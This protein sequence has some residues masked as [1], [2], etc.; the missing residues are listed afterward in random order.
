MHTI[1]KTHSNHLFTLI[2][3]L[4]VIAIIA[5]LASILLPALSSSRDRVREIYCINNIRQIGMGLELYMD[6]SD[7]TFPPISMVPPGG[8]YRWARLVMPYMGGGEYGTAKGLEDA[9]K[10]RFFTCQSDDIQRGD[11]G[12]KKCSYA[13]NFEIQE[14]NLTGTKPPVKRTIIQNSPETIV[15][16]ERWNSANTIQFSLGTDPTRT[17]NYHRFVT[18][19]FLFADG[20]AEGMDAYSTRNNSNYLWKFVK[21]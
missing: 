7:D 12:P 13:L 4:V 2:E 21:P 9:R 18:N 17:G 6:E 8:S 15:G 16:G 1:P 19:S 14:G 20:H 10:M 11:T 3:L 5:I